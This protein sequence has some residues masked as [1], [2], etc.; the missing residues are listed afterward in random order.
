MSC[1]IRYLWVLGIYSL[2]VTWLKIIRK[3]ES[4]RYEFTKDGLLKQV[5]LE[6]INFS[7]LD[8]YVRLRFHCP[9]SSVTDRSDPWNSTCTVSQLVV[10]STDY[11]AGI[12]QHKRKGEW[13]EGKK[14]DW[15]TNIPKGCTFC[16]ERFEQ[17]LDS[18]RIQTSNLTVPILFSSTGKCCVELKFVDSKV[19][20]SS[21]PVWAYRLWVEL[22]LE[23]RKKY[24]STVWYIVLLYHYIMLV[25][26]MD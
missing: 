20:S 23:E 17:Q 5:P 11:W 2:H 6:A 19:D 12:V 13:E 1:P 9:V 14:Q 7:N 10:F 24:G 15:T 25:S 18:W 3:D 21:G 26:A 16:W 8:K 4:R 22:S